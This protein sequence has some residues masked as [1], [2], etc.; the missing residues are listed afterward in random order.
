MG[1]YEAN[2]RHTQLIMSRGVITIIK[3]ICGRKGNPTRNFNQT[4]QV[5]MWT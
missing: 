5:I 2:V 4:K 3:L 1:N